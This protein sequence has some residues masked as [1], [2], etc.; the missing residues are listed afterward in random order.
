MYCLIKY[1]YTNKASCCYLF[2]RW[3]VPFVLQWLNENDDVSMEYLHS[4]YERDKKDDVRI[5][6]YWVFHLTHI[7]SIM[8]VVKHNI[9]KYMYMYVMSWYLIIILNL[10]LPDSLITLNTVK[11]T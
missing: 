4:A 7:N 11:P 2:F 5:I 1:V 6:L 9:Y 8:N 10:K 3:F